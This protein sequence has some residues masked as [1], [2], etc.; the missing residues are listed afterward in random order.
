[1]PLVVGKL[2]P[3]QRPFLV[4]NATDNPIALMPCPLPVTQ[5]WPDGNWHS[6]G[7]SKQERD[8]IDSCIAT[9][10]IFQLQATQESTVE[11]VYSLYQSLSISNLL[12]SLQVLT[13]GLLSCS[14]TRCPFPSDALLTELHPPGSNSHRHLDPARR[15][16]PTNLGRSGDGSATA[17]G[18]TSRRYS[19]RDPH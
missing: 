8:M 9:S 4:L 7:V 19:V 1:M 13:S 14:L 12:Y 18:A 2:V 6:M 3:F 5:L 10:S 15:K 11:L 16:R 17:T